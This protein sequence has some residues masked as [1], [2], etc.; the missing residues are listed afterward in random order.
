MKTVGLHRRILSLSSSRPPRCMDEIVLHTVIFL[1]IHTVLSS[2]MMSAGGNETPR[3]FPFPRCA[4]LV[5]LQLVRLPEAERRLVQLLE[6]DASISPNFFALSSRR[7]RD[8]SGAALAASPS[9]AFR[10][11]RD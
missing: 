11:E 1:C 6:V 3:S 10:V 9:S 4:V 8:R 7:R 2:T 5:R